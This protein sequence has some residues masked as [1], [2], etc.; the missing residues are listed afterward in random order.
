MSEPNTETSINE[1]SFCGKHKDQVVKLI[2]GEG[3]SICNNCVD[4]CVELLEEEK[5]ASKRSTKL[6]ILIL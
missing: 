3:V 2:V 6:K 1:C 5:P 4:F